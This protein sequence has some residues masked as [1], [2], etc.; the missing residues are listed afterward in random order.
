MAGTI[1]HSWDGTVLTVTSDSGSSSMDLKGSAGPIGPRGPQGAPGVSV[2]GSGGVTVDLSNYYTKDETDN[3]I[4]TAI[5]DIDPGADIDLSNYYTKQ[6]INNKGYATE[7]FVTNKIAEAQLSGGDSG[8]VDLSGYATKDD[9]NTY[10]KL[11]N[12]R[13]DGAIT[14]DDGANTLHLFPIGI[15]SVNGLWIGNDGAG[16]F[17]SLTVNSKTVA[18]QEWVTAQLAALDGSEVEY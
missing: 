5:N 8:S 15:Q 10:R 7:T 12:T 6:E 14:I 13:F 17:T 18:T 3:A 11:D 4:Q 9:L 2:G 16:Q 1:T